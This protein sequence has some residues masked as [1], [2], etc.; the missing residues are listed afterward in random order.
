MVETKFCIFLYLFI[1]FQVFSFFQ[2]S[3]EKCWKSIFWPAIG[4]R[5]TQTL[6]LKYSTHLEIN[7]YN[8]FLYRCL[9][10]GS[11]QQWNDVEHAAT[12][13]DSCLAKPQHGQRRLLHA[14]LCNCN[15]LYNNNNNTIRKQRPV[16]HF[17]GW[18][19]GTVNN[20]NNRDNNKRTKNSVIKSSLLNNRAW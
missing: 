4:V 2:L 12:D 18:Q 17:A 19:E 15:R 7:N 5:N 6:V 3:H 10:W 11:L 9:C 8:C 14:R 1:N 13:G 16:V 20:N